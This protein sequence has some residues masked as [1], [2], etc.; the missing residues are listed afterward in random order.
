MCDFSTVERCSNLKVHL[1]KDPDFGE[2]A[3][4]I[5]GESSIGSCTLNTGSWQIGGDF[6]CNYANGAK[7][8]SHVALERQR[9]IGLLNVAIYAG[10]D[11]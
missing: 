8:A 11:C 10:Y 9:I 4:V 6:H 2:T 3:Q 7:G 5:V 1:L